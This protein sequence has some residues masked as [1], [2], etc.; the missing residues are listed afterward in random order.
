MN[1]VGHISMCNIGLPRMIRGEPKPVLPVGNDRMYRGCRWSG[2]AGPPGKA[3]RMPRS[4]AVHDHTT[5][6][7]ARTASVVAAPSLAA[8]ASAWPAPTMH[9]TAQH[10]TAQHGTARPAQHPTA[11]H[12]STHRERGGRLV[13]GGK[14]L[15][16]GQ[17]LC[18]R[19]DHGA[20]QAAQQ[21]PVG[22]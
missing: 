15:R 10:S 5:Q 21:L 14:G 11:H 6:R 3:S 12:R 1:R 9:S 13:A 8:K 16:V 22:G 18:E 2:R 7:T 20:L 19:H 17:L 4:A